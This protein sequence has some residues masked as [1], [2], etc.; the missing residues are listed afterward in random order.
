MCRLHG[1]CCPLLTSLT[2]QGRCW[3]DVSFSVNA[4]SILHTNPRSVCGHRVS[5]MLEA[6]QAPVIIPSSNH[7]QSTTSCIST[8]GS[9]KWTSQAYLHA[10]HFIF[11]FIRSKQ[12][13]GVSCLCQEGTCIISKSLPLL[14]ITNHLQAK[15]SGHKYF[16]LRIMIHLLSDVLSLDTFI[17]W[18][19]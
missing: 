3:L 16:Q 13:G 5:E 6:Y 2:K 8:F 9:S 11:I 17:C 15:L 7:L 19:V 14:D 10:L 18:G 12:T 1:S 4:W